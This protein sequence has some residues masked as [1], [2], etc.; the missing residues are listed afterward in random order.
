MNKIKGEVKVLSGKLGKNE[1]KI[2][3]GRRML[4]KI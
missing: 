4:G 2:E 3:E 1:E